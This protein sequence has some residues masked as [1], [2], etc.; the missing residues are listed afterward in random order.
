MYELTIS[1]PPKIPQILP[2]IVPTEQQMKKRV[3]SPDFMIRPM[4]ITKSKQSNN[5]LNRDWDSQRARIRSPSPTKKQTRSFRSKNFNYK[6]MV[7]QLYAE[8][9]KKLDKLEKSVAK[10]GFKN[11]LLEGQRI[12]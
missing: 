2:F 3:K 11:L 6:D 1:P 7:D 5:S 4:R 12:S 9:A 10:V 8:E